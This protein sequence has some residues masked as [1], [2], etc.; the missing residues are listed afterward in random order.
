[1]W[2]ARILRPPVAASVEVKKKLR[3]LD[4]RRML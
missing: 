2:T 1:M 4:F 3:Q